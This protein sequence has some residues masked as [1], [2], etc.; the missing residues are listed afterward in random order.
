MQDANR[1]IGRVLVL[2]AGS[3]AS[4][5][6]ETQIGR[7]D[8]HLAALRSGIDT[9]NRHVPVLPPVTGTCRALEGEPDRAAIA[10]GDLFRLGTINADDR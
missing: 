9:L 1:A 4:Q 10:D 3:A 5:R 6:L 2:P 7:I 8:R